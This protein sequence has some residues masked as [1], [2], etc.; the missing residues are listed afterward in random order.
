M[1]SRGVL[2]VDAALDGNDVALGSS[3]FRVRVLLSVRA[4]KTRSTCG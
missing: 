3:Q 4:K 2:I 1:Q